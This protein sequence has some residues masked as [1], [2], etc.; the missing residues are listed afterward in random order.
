MAILSKN[1]DIVVS[2]ETNEYLDNIELERQRKIDE[3]QRRWYEMKLR[4][5]GDAMKQEYPS[6]P[7]EA[8]ESANEGLWYGP[9]ITKIR[10]QGAICNVPYDEFEKVHTSWDIGIHD[11]TSIWCFQLGKGGQVR[12]INYYENWNERPDHYCDWLN[13]QKYR[14]GRH[15]F[16]HDGLKRD[17]NMVTYVDLCKK[18]LDGRFVVLPREQVGVFDGVNLVRSTLGR[19]VFD[20][21]NCQK[22]LE[23]LEAYKKEWDDRLGCYKN[24]PLHDLH[25]HCADS[26]RYLCVG[27]QGMEASLHGSAENDLKAVNRY[28]GL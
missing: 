7:K 11:S 10:A 16:P 18:L 9:T 25:S 20:E 12:V 3:E 14:F 4:M 15:I 21:K 5:L 1:N 17:N 24:T 23:H 26:M 2:K 19:C 22:G 28:Y 27:L 8:F 13:K 6:T